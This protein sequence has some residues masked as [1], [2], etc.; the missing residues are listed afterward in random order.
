MFFVHQMPSPAASV[1]ENRAATVDKPSATA[2]QGSREKQMYTLT[3][4]HAAKQSPAATNGARQG[5]CMYLAASSTRLFGEKPVL[6]TI[7]GSDWRPPG[8]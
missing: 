5:N 4:I 2:T 6:N 8:G 3:A 1:K 7:E